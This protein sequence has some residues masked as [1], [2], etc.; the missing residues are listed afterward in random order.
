MTKQAIG[1]AADLTMMAKKNRSERS[2]SRPNEECFNC[3]KK[4]Y[5]IRDC[6]NSSSKKRKLAEELMEEAKH[7]QWKK[8]KVKFAIVNFALNNDNS[9][10][11]LYPVGRV[12]MTREADEEGEWYLNSCASRHIC[13]NHEIFVNFYPKSYKFITA[14]RNIIRSKQVGTV[15]F[16][17][18]NGILTLSNIAYVPEYN[19]NLIFLGQ[20]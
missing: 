14:S 7:A 16:P 15:F 11:K 5:Y 6:C 4:G 12:F 20:L 8:N 17:L 2:D 3:G 1:V 10:I 9:D 18:K 13:N 19:S